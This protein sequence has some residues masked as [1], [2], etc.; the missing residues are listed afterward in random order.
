MLGKRHKADLSMKI[1]KLF[2]YRDEEE[3]SD[4]LV[5]VTGHTVKLK[6]MPFK[7]QDIASAMAELARS[8]QYK[9]RVV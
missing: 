8:I 7:P 4:R 9:Q 5:R 3:K 2:K 1:E 6:D